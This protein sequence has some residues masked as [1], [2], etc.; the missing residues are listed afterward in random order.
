MKKILILAFLFTT[1][2]AH[3]QISGPIIQDDGTTLGRASILNFTG[4]GVTC[5]ISGATVT[6]AVSGGSFGN[7]T[8]SG[9]TAT[10]SGTPMQLS[11]SGGGVLE[12]TAGA[13]GYAALR[14]RSLVLQA[15]PASTFLDLYDDAGNLGIEIVGGAGGTAIIGFAS[16]AGTTDTNISRSGV[17]ILSMPL[18]QGTAGTTTNPSYGGPGASSNTGWYFS[19]TDEISASINGTQRVIVQAGALQVNALTIRPTTDNQGEVGT[20]GAAF[21]S[22]RIYSTIN[23][24]IYNFDTAATIAAG[25]GAG[26]GPTIAVTGGGIAGTITL[27]TGTSPGTNATILTVTLPDPFGSTLRCTVV[28]AS[29]NT[30]GLAATIWFYDSSN[31]T[32]T[33]FRLDSGAVGLTATTAYRWEYT[34]VHY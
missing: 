6:C 15:N 12:V 5:T 34:C 22:S 16:A 21:T 31:N 4:A 2:I 33:T 26:T 32:A 20:S 14:A 25:A 24:V 28:G 10:T 8:F 29:A 1:Q 13:G 9:N 30:I 18:L 19:T 3:A 23:E 17:N 7:W 27:T 11:V